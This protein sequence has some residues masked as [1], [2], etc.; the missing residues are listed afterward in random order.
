M[1]EAEAFDDEEFEKQE[2]ALFAGE[3]DTEIP[4][5]KGPRFVPEWLALDFMQWLYDYHPEIRSAHDLSH[6]N[7]MYYVRQFEQAMGIKRGYT[8]NDWIIALR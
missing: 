6:S 2:A 8:A 5:S 4:E 1:S 3:D 7:I